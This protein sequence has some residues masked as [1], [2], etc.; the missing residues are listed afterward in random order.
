MKRVI[1]FLLVLAFCLSMSCTAFAATDS[2]ADNNVVPNIPK[3]GDT[4]MI[5]VAVMALALVALAAVVV[6][7]RKSTKSTQ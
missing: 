6:V 7:Y 4:I 1:S 5:W 2:A 3:T